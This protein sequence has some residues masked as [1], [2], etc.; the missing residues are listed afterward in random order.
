MDIKPYDSYDESQ[1]T[2]LWRDCGLLVPWN[3]PSRDI[4]RKLEVQ[5]ELFLVA[6]WMEKSSL[7]S[8]PD[9]TDIGVGSTILPFIQII[10]TPG[11]AET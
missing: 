8:W 4:Q 11:L 6:G 1:V 7:R 9:M 2:R 3:D 5:P 10:G